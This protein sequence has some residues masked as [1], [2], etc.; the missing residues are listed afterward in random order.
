[1]LPLCLPTLQQGDYSIRRLAAAAEE[2]GKR[3]AGETTPQPE[4][5]IPAWQPG[6]GARMAAP[7]TGGSLSA[8]K[9]PLMQHLNPLF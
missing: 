7:E 3:L 9:T 4:A 2:E 5:R 8:A 1:M 6:S